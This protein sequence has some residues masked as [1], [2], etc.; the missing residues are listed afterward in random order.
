MSSESF[1]LLSLSPVLNLRCFSVYLFRPL[2]VQPTKEARA[3]GIK[4]YH[5]WQNVKSNALFLFLYFS[6]PFFMKH[7]FCVRFDCGTRRQCVQYVHKILFTYLLPISFLWMSI[8]FFFVLLL[9]IVHIQWNVVMRCILFSYSSSGAFPFAFSSTHFS[10]SSGLLFLD[11]WCFS[12]VVKREE[13]WKM[14]I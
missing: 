7:V 11:F 12:F 5:L 8:L 2:S 10:Y 13:E 14:K 6:S 3:N 9:W 4:Y 1:E